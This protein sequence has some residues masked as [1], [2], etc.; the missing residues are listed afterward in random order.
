MDYF[1]SKCL[2]LLFVLHVLCFNAVVPSMSST[3]VFFF[4]SPPFFEQVLSH[5]SPAFSSKCCLH[6]LLTVRH[7]QD[8]FLFQWI[9][10]C[11]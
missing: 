1:F 11:R 9:P 10:Q 5:C 6:V 3:L 7:P 2:F 4:F 8:F